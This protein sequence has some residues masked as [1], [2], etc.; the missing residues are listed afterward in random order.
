MLIWDLTKLLCGETWGH[1]TL[2]RRNMGTPHFDAQA[3][4]SESFE[5]MSPLAAHDIAPDSL[6]RLKSFEISADN[7]LCPHLPTATRCRILRRERCLDSGSVEL[8]MRFKTASFRDTLC[9][10]SYVLKRP[11]KILYH[12]RPK[13]WLNA[14]SFQDWRC[15][16]RCRAPFSRYRVAC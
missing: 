14:K 4:F 9:C 7:Y 11:S 5:T 15:G 10:S 1:H 16:L 2:M 12:R 3:R 6:F 13:Q 8:A